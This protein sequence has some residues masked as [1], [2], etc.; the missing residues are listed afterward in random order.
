MFINVGVAWTHHFAGRPA[1]AIR[2]ALKAREIFP[3]FEEA[4][5]VLT[6]A[7]EIL[8]RYE[9]AAAII[10]QQP[11]WGVPID[12]AVLLEAFRE[13]GPER[14][15]RTR[16]ELMEAVWETAPPIVHFARAIV[17]RYLDETDEALYHVERMVEEH[18]GPCVFLGVDPNLAPL[19]DHPRYQA[20]LRQVGVSPQ[21]MLSTAHTAST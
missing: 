4:G 12:G 17:H 7:Y 19:R 2:E 20:A 5:N 1:D 11:C 10:A 21:R 15:W 6:S 3:G 9:D 14:Y 18:V 13:G 8:G 16:L